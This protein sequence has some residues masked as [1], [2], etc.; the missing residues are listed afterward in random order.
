MSPNGYHIRNLT[1]HFIRTH[2]LTNILFDPINARAGFRPMNSE[3][4]S[5][6]LLILTSRTSFT[7]L[8][9]SLSIVTL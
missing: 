1:K 9:P 2:V 3:S 5:R 4:K 7:A 8:Y 6:P